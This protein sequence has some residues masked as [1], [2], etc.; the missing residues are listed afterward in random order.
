MTRV[1]LVAMQVRA[2]L[3]DYASGETFRRRMEGLMEEAAKTVDFSM[4]TIVC[5]PETIGLWLSFIP[6][7]YD[8]VRDCKTIRQAVLRGI[9]ANLGRFLGACWR[10]KNF[11]ISTIFLEVALEA[12]LT[13]RETFSNLAKQYGCYLQAGT[14]YIPRIEDEPVKGRHALGNQVYNTAY[15]FNPKGVILQRLPK[16]YLSP[17]LE[18]AFRFTAGD[19]VDLHPVDTPLGRMGILI[20]YD[21][22]HESLVEH[23]D[24]LG[25]EI[26]LSPSHS[27]RDWEQP[28]GFNNAITVGEAWARHGVSAMLQGRPNIKYAV[29]SMMAG[30]VFDLEGQGCSHIAYN[31]GEVGAPASQFL[32]AQASSH[33]SEEIVVAQVDLPGGC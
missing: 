27:D 8:D 23:Y 22:F 24:S 2:A 29:V 9:P 26:I 14:I 32:L 19:R 1:N 10:F 11:G 4:P 33:T 6:E 31:T 25:V 5:F 16:N 3:E 13:Y 15:L 20:C 18:R 17:P 28:A 30:R 21:G 12:E 7:V